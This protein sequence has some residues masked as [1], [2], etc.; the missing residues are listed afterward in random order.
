MVLHTSVRALWFAAHVR[1]VNRTNVHRG[2]TSRQTHGLQTRRRYL[3]RLSFQLLLPVGVRHC[4]LAQAFA[5]F[6]E[7]C[8]TKTVQLFLILPQLSVQHP[9]GHAA[10]DRVEQAIF[11][12]DCVTERG[13]DGSV[14][15]MALRADAT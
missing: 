6:G 1:G 3:R 14:V 12:P 4:E 5:G 2:Y 10:L 9:D 8:Q 7:T 11:L 15:V 13:G